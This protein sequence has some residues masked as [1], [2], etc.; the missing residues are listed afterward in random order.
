[1]WFV[2]PDMPMAKASS[3]PMNLLVSTTLYMII[4]KH[5]R[6]LVLTFKYFEI[7]VESRVDCSNNIHIR[8]ALLRYCK[9]VLLHRNV[10][11][12]KLNMLLIN[13]LAS[14]G[15]LALWRMTCMPTF[16]TKDAE[17]IMKSKIVK[18]NFENKIGIR[19]YNDDY[20]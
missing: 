2:T 12:A 16:T 6:L 8:D 13:Y 9:K 7:S 15:V 5:K 19:N 4:V 17:E 3:L 10:L 20:K 1:M 14:N 18:P 11:Y